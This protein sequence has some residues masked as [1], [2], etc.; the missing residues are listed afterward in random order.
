MGIV[1]QL[2]TIKLNMQEQ[3]YIDRKM[4]KVEKILIKTK[5]GEKR[6]N[7]EISQDKRTFW[8][9]SLTVQIPKK[10]FRVKKTGNKLL[11][12]VDVAEGAI[13]EQIRRENEKIK[14]FV[15]KRKRNR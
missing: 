15:R 8:N 13:S 1:Y 6:I 10:I 5:D 12:V 11:E 7:L 3:D 14:D 4:K 9:V 2:G